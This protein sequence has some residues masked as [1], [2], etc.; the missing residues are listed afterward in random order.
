MKRVATSSS[1]SHSRPLATFMSKDIF[2]RILATIFIVILI[3]A[4]HRFMTVGPRPDHPV[5]AK[6]PLL[7]AHRGGAALWPENTLFAFH[8]AANMGVDVLEMDV[9]LTADDNLVVIHD[10]TVD[11]TTNGS[12]RVVDMTV[13]EIKKL[14]AGYHFTP[15]NGVT[16]PYRSRGVTIPTLDEVLTDFPDFP[17]NL[18]IKDDDTHAAER[19]SEIIVAHHAQERV[20][21]VSFH[22]APLNYFRKL[23][24]RVA[25]AAGPGETR[26]FYFLS[27]LH[28][29]RFH[30]PHADAYQVPPK[31]SIAHFDAQ[32]FIEH[33][34][35]MNQKVQY[36][37]INDADDMRRLL[38]MGA[39]GV[40]TDRPDMG[41]QVFKE[42]GF[43]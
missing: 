30:R 42:M 3:F 10:G 33:A 15:D 27:L 25:T 26:V 35:K 38:A 4:L 7:F 32:E 5:L 1:P 8:N 37:T 12:G 29:W 13:A 20:I 17:L 31:R 36:W 18:E 34:H 23:Q 40:M 6:S 39:D 14:D 16:Y 24:P 28:L 41:M 21:V 2:Y 19:L 43:K 22:D 9:H 11:R